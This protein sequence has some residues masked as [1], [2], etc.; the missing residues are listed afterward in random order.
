MAA[1]QNILAFKFIPSH[2]M[3]SSL[4]YF[5]FFKTLGKESTSYCCEVAQQMPMAMFT[6]QARHQINVKL[7]RSSIKKK[8]LIIGPQTVKDIR[9]TVNVRPQLPPSLLPL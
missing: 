3:R 2:N 6:L 9:H 8:D 7:P 4:I 5:S 1:A